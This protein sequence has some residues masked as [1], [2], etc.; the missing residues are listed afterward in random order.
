MKILFNIGYYILGT[1]SYVVYLAMDS[2]RRQMAVYKADAGTDYVYLQAAVL[3]DAINQGKASISS[4]VNLATLANDSAP[5]GVTSGRITVTNEPTPELPFAYVGQ[6]YGSLTGNDLDAFV[7]NNNAAP[8]APTAPAAPSLQNS[9]A[10]NF[11]SFVNDL[12]SF[13][14]TGLISNPVF[15]LA[16]GVV[17][18]RLGWLKKLGIGR[19]RK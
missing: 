8:T 12:T 19:K 9:I 14:I 3:A 18:W 10:A 15:W 7:F 2:Q 5:N 4:N 13:N 1:T 6:A 16:A 11:N 17:A